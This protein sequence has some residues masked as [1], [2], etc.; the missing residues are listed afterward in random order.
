MRGEFVKPVERAKPK[1]GKTGPGKRQLRWWNLV[2]AHRKQGT[3]SEHGYDHHEVLAVLEPDPFSKLREKAGFLELVKKE[4]ADPFGPVNVEEFKN[5][6]KNKKI[7]TAEFTFEKF[8]DELKDTGLVE[9]HAEDG[10]LWLNHQACKAASG[11]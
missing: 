3:L 2:E 4:K 11:S 9:H 6:L 8:L 5:H 1:N 10:T 7:F